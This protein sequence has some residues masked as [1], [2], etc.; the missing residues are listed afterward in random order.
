MKT[1]TRDMSTELGELWFKEF[2]TKPPLSSRSFPSSLYYHLRL[3]QAKI[4]THPAETGAACPALPCPAWLTPS[5][6]FWQMCSSLSLANYLYCRSSPHFSPLC[7]STS[8]SHPISIVAVFM[9]S[10]PHGMM[11]MNYSCIRSKLYPI[12]I[13]WVGTCEQ[14]SLSYPF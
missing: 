6:L 2:I 1:K 8:S 13:L 10:S 12:Y 14:P 11:M 3:L 4:F 9:P 5:V 7:F